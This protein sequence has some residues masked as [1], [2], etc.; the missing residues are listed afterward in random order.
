MTILEAIDIRK[1]RRTFLP[2]AMSENQITHLQSLIKQ[3]NAESGLHIQLLRDATQAFDGFKK[4]YGMLKGVQSCLALIG[5]KADEHLEEKC[6]YYGEL[7]VLEAT[8]MSLGTCW[9]GGTYD[10]KS[11][12]FALKENEVLTCVIPIGNV[13][14]ETNREKFIHK[15]AVRKTKS[16]EEL[17]TS[18][19]PAPDFFIAGMQAVRKAPSAVNRQPVMF[20][21]NNGDVSASVSTKYAFALI[22]FG[23]A[24]AHFV[25]ASGGKFEWGLG[26][27]LEFSN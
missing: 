20:S 4:S 11:N 14:E 26:G 8:S 17:Y 6:G 22:D 9:V 5:N 1:S 23:I 3:Y 12:A 15:L 19:A 21:Y 10:K 2:T 7:L 25:V 13:P 27:K 24:K 16:I 18:D